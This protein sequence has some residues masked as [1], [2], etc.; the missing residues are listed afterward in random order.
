MAKC[1]MCKG[2]GV[3]LGVLGLLRWFRCRD[4]GMDWNK[5]KAVR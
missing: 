3:L 4:C 5:R 2:P 1:P